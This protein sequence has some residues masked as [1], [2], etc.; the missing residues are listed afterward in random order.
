[1]HKTF[2]TA[3]VQ[4]QRQVHQQHPVAPKR[5]RPLNAHTDRD[6]ADIVIRVMDRAEAE[7]IDLARAI[8]TRVGPERRARR[9]RN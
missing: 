1:M 2:H 9:K 4:L 7:G 6:M 8:L 3:F 5:G